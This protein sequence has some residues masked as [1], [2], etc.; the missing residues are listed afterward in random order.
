MSHEIYQFKIT[1]NDSAPKVW[2]RILVPTDY[3]FFDLHVAMQN[4]MGWTDSHLHAFRF[5]NKENRWWAINIA[6]PSP[7]DPFEV[8]DER[9][10]KI[11]DYFGKTFG[12]C[13]YEYDFGDGWEHTVL[14]EKTLPKKAGE[15][16]PQCVVGKNACPPD[17][18]GG[19]WGYKGLQEILKNPKHQEHKDMLEWLAVES[20]DEFNPTH[21]DPAEVEFEDPKERLKE[22]NAGFGK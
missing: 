4:A 20:A 12:Q 3:T 5:A 13:A 17:D 8:V 1:L 6:T 22:W 11:A 15:K 10:A 21:F 16:Y 19:V 18:C 14:L 7:D 2:R 9:Q